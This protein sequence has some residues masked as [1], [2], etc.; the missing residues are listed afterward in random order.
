[1]KT[2]VTTIALAV[3][4]ASPAS[5][6]P[7]VKYYNAIPSSWAPAI[8]TDPLP[9]GFADGDYVARDPDP[10]IRSELLR[11]PPNDG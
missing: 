6:Q 10:A 9:R 2:L 1:M 8:T 7:A 3:A 5:A 11:D 4:T